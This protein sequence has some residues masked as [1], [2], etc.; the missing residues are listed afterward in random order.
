MMSAFKITLYFLNQLTHLVTSALLAGTLGSKSRVP[1]Y[2]AWVP[3]PSIAAWASHRGSEVVRRCT[4]YSQRY[5]RITHAA[6]VPLATS[7]CA[8]GGPLLP[9]CCTT[10]EGA[11][12]QRSCALVK[13]PG[14]QTKTA[15]CTVH[16]TVPKYVAKTYSYSGKCSAIGSRIDE[17]PPL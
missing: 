2:A 3:V 5:S 7:N 11:V 17:A 8:H 9:L 14:R 1:L 10:P 13:Q 4:F 6:L 15:Q 12:D 16:S